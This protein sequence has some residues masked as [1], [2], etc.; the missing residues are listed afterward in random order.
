MLTA[1]LLSLFHLIK[2][3]NAA[4]ADGN[5]NNNPDENQEKRDKPSGKRKAKTSKK[6]EEEEEPP[7]RPPSEEE[8]ERGKDDPEDDPEEAEFREKV[9]KLSETQQIALLG[10]MAEICES[11]DPYKTL[12]PTIRLS[13]LNEVLERIPAPKRK[14]QEKTSTLSKKQKVDSDDSDEEPE[15]KLKR[16]RMERLFLL[17]T[18]IN[19]CK[20]DLEN[21]Q[22]EK[23]Q[24]LNQNPELLPLSD[25]TDYTKE[26]KM[27]MATNRVERIM[28]KKEKE[29]KKVKDLED[30]IKELEELHKKEPENGEIQLDINLLKMQIV[31]CKKVITELEKKLEKANKNLNDLLD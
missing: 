23:E 29:E 22:K 10:K 13:L 28:K 1:Y 17:N 20:K 14:T 5:S 27:L 24:L 4:Q 3:V 12:A 18:N 16:L 6:V 2:Y 30:Q 25:K 7:L 31:N 15:A 9:L 8:N 21:A 19:Q 11:S 26:E